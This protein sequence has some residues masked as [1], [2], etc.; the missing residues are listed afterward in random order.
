M[1]VQSPLD[2]SINLLKNLLAKAIRFLVENSLF[3]IG[4]AII[5]RVGRRDRDYVTDVGRRAIVAGLKLGTLLYSSPTPALR[6]R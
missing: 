6:T 2:E 3:L 4:G 5:A 1:V